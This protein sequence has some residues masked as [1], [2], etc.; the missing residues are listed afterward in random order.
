MPQT[1]SEALH[2]LKVDKQKADAER[3]KEAPETDAPAK[4]PAA[5]SS[6][7]EKKVAGK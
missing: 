1:A 3:A 7:P 5:K 4:K 6:K 2:Q